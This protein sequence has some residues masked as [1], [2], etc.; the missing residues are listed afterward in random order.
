MLTG[1]QIDFPAIATETFE[2]QPGVFTWSAFCGSASLEE[3]RLARD[4]V[5][6]KLQARNGR[7]RLAHLAPHT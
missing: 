6:L 7:S 4:A 5:H 1:E 3:L 2:L